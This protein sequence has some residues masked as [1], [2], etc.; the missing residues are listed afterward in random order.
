MSVIGVGQYVAL[1]G[2]VIQSLGPGVGKAVHEPFGEAP[3]YAE[4][5]A[6]VERIRFVVGGPDHS[7]A[8]VWPQLIDVHTGIRLQSAGDRL[9]DIALA[10]A[11]QSAAADIRDLDRRIET[12]LPL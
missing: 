6:V 2:A 7:V 3:V 11:A 10:L 1:C 8:F 12:D 5:Q 4:L 9:V